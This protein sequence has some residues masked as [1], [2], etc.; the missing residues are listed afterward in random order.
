ML[1]HPAERHGQLEAQDLSRRCVQSPHSK[2]QYQGTPRDFDP[3]LPDFRSHMAEDRPSVPPPAH[4]HHP[5]KHDVLNRLKIASST[6][7]KEAHM[8]STNTKSPL[9]YVP[10]DRVSS[11]RTSSSP[12]SHLERPSSKGPPAHPIGKPPPLIRGPA[13]PDKPLMQAPSGGSITQGT[14]VNQLSI[15]QQSERGSIS[16]G[17]PRIDS[18]RQ[19]MDGSITR[20]TPMSYE[21]PGSRP[22]QPSGRPESVPRMPFDATAVAI[23][24]SNPPLYDMRYEIYNPMNNARRL[25]PTGSSFYAS[26]P[27]HT[28]GTTYLTLMDDFH[29]AQQMQDLAQRRGTQESNQRQMSPRSRPEMGREAA[30]QVKNVPQGM[31]YHPGQIPSSV[32]SSIPERLT[33]Q[34]VSPRDATPPHSD[35]AVSSTGS[36]SSTQS[37]AHMSQHSP[38]IAGCRVQDRRTASPPQRHII[39]H[40]ADSSHYPPSS[41][42][43]LNG[44]SP[45]ATL[46]NVAANAPALAVPGDKRPQISPSASDTSKWEDHKRLEANRRYEDQQMRLE[47]QAAE[48]REEQRREEARDQ[49]PNSRPG[50]DPRQV[51][52]TDSRHYRPDSR[53]GAESRHSSDPRHMPDPKHHLDHRLPQVH[54]I[55][56]PD[57]P[58]AP[59]QMSVDVRQQNKYDKRD[60]NS[61]SMNHNGQRRQQAGQS[62]L[63]AASLIDVIIT[64]AINNPTDN[65]EGRENIRTSAGITNRPVPSPGPGHPKLQAEQ[66]THYKPHRHFEQKQEEMG[67]E[68]RPD[69]SRPPQRNINLGEYIEEIIHKDYVNER[70]LA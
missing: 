51:N 20:G 55:S 22:V 5:Q 27:H 50:P 30:Q 12:Y 48:R 11:Q 29:T 1:P 63:T 33:S 26:V 58:E 41:S 47:R 7:Q 70:K 15:A 52:N 35:I 8:H 61:A 36:W 4:S 28:Q 6:E 24:R 19:G 60:V 59:S 66:S 13:K 18:G 65:R 46:V 25:S 38:G 16:R 17:T 37:R 39:Q 34:N 9:A 57:R 44:N 45:F 62:T 67:K 31:I 68:A 32:A 54:V 40:G 53:H 10:M 23:G 42:A 43:L 21:T 69:S 14:P 56:R 64:N 49:R 3:R 2:P